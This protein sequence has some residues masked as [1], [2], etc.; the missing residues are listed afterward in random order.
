MI[1]GDLRNGETIQ[2]ETNKKYPSM[3]TPFPRKDEKML[4]IVKR[5]KKGSFYIHET[6]ACKNDFYYEHANTLLEKMHN[7]RNDPIDNRIVL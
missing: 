5:E 6:S 2:L 7:M 3:R 4:Y 1:H